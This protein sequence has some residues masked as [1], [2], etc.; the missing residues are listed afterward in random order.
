MYMIKKTYENKYI[1]HTKVN[2]CKMVPIKKK[3]AKRYRR[4]V[5][6]TNILKSQGITHKAKQQGIPIVKRAGT[7]PQQMGHG[8]YEH[9]F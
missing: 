4:P 8:P 5:I 1:K 9:S 7:R 3:M 2:N 6:K